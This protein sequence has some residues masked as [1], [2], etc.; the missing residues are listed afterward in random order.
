[1]TAYR[2]RGFRIRVSQLWRAVAFSRTVIPTPQ[3]YTVA[4]GVGVV[5]GVI[6]NLWLDWPWWLGPV[7][8][9]IA[10]WL[11]AL[12]TAFRGPQRSRTIR[13][14]HDQLRPRGAKD[15]HDKWTSRSLQEAPFAAVGFAE[16][17]EPPCLGGTS[18]R[19]DQLTAITI[20][21]GNPGLPSA[22]FIEV[23]TAIDQ[24]PYEILLHMEADC[25][26]RHAAG[27]SH[28]PTSDPSMLSAEIDWSPTDVVIDDTT[29]TAQRAELGD[30]W[31]LVIQDTPD[32]TVVIGG[33]R[34]ATLGSAVLK[35]LEASDYTAGPDS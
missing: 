4:A 23:T 12:S 7:S 3:S 31:T 24:D 21:Y 27:P 16:H 2:S 33:H 18:D 5:A 20:T 8:F 6:W 19:D 34:G 1:M 13:A 25:L 26:R 35:S 9:V 22:P 14:V 32:R 11:S 30:S 17:P 15:R 10:A 29:R 28:L